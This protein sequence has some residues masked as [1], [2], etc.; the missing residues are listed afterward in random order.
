MTKAQVKEQNITTCFG[1]LY[2]NIHFEPQTL[3]GAY[4]TSP[5]CQLLCT[6]TEASKQILALGKEDRDGCNL[7][8]QL[9]HQ[10]ENL[11][12]VQQSTLACDEF[13]AFD[14]Q[15]QRFD[16]IL[17]NGFIHHRHP[18]NYN[19]DF[20]LMHHLLKVDGYLVIKVYYEPIENRI[21]G[22]LK[23]GKTQPLC[24]QFTLPELSVLLKS[25]GFSPIAHRLFSDT[26][27]QQYLMMTAQKKRPVSSLKL[28]CYSP[29]E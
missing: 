27:K 9:G 28:P 12:L 21:A 6:M 10:V 24:K 8:M 18:Q 13:K 2:H 23:T 22:Q 16:A 3:I 7:L 11:Q 20:D 4:P 5:G 1:W 29:A 26:G 15:R 17:D 19:K 25:K 14:E